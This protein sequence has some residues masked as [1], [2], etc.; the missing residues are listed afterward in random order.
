MKFS[1]IK[2]YVQSAKHANSKKKA[3]SG[4]SRELEISV[5]LNAYEKEVHS[6]GQTL[7]EAHKC[8]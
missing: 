3:A 4:K 7:S 8:H 1:I 2:N 6:S 5:A